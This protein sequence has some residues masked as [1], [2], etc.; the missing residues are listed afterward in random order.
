MNAVK[1]GAGMPSPKN[2]L[3]LLHVVENLKVRV[4]CIPM[5]FSLEMNTIHEP[6]FNDDA[7]FIVCRRHPGPGG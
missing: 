1:T 5:N 2:V 4:F 3:Q 7:R 6:L